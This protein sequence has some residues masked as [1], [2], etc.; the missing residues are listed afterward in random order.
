[1]SEGSRLNPVE[2]IKKLRRERERKVALGK[3]DD[4]FS[5]ADFSVLRDKGLPLFLQIECSNGESIVGVRRFDDILSRCIYQ[6]EIGRYSTE[7][8]RYIG[9]PVERLKEGDV[10]IFTQPN[11]GCVEGRERKSF[12]ETYGVP[13][14]LA[15]EYPSRYFQE[16]D[17]SEW[18]LRPRPYGPHLHVLE[19]GV[20]SNAKLFM[21]GIPN[22]FNGPF[23]SRNVKIDGTDCFIVDS[24]VG[25]GGWTTRTEEQNEFV[26]E[27]VR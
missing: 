8:R 19:V 26:L 5:G 2:R 15:D 12:L 16:F 22:F 1:M 18:R 14:S 17:P 4:F 20:I 23:P 3:I 21:Q 24:V 6:E 13:G 27:A 9:I 10:V 25:M 7:I 11:L